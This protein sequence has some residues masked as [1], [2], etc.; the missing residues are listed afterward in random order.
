MIALEVGKPELAHSSKQVLLVVLASSLTFAF[1]VGKFVC[2]FF[3]SLQAML[4][5]YQAKL[6]L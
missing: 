3:E 6:R 5:I 1:L 2:D 4:S